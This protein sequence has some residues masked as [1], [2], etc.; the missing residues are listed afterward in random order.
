MKYRIILRD[1]RYVVQSQQDSHN[2]DWFDEFCEFSLGE[3][4]NVC[5]ITGT[6]S[7]IEQAKLFV[8]YL[9]DKREFTIV[10]EEK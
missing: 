10:W 7:N 3:F 1:S 5:T 8:K 9:K 2:Y 4:V 6:C